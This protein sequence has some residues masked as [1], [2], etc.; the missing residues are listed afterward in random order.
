MADEG[1]EDDGFW[2]GRLR[3]EPVES[4]DSVGM[5]VVVSGG[6]PGGPPRYR[7]PVMKTFA[8]WQAAVA[9]ERRHVSTMGSGLVA[10]E[11]F[12]GLVLQED[13]GYDG[14]LVSTAVSHSRRFYGDVEWTVEAEHLWRQLCV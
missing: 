7:D 8:F 6:R 12:S 2:S 5:A 11:L 14:C 9:K 1:D 10:E 13:L 3:D 4:V